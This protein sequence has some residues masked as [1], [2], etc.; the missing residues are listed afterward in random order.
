[1]LYVEAPLMSSMLTC[2]FTAFMLLG[3]SIVAIVTAEALARS[4]RNCPQCR[5]RNER[6]ARYCARCGQQLRR[7]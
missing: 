3:L 7:S 5:H 6:T 1:M 4:R 2:L